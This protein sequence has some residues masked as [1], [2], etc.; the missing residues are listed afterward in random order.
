MELTLM[1]F[2]CWKNRTFYFTENVNLL[3][4]ASGAGKSTICEAIFF[5]LYGGMNN[6]YNI[7][8]KKDTTKVIMQFNEYSIT[9]SKPPE[10]ISV[11]IYSDKDNKILNGTDAQSWI[12]TKFGSKDLWIASSYLSQSCKHYLMTESNSKKMDLLS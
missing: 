9:R 6:I 1:N 5:C 3:S 11:T 2:R 4:G 10:N 7:T 12:N 8:E